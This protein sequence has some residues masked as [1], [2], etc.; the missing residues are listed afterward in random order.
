LCI[1]WQDACVPAVWA[2]VA[3]IGIHDWRIACAGR[4]GVAQ[5]LREGLAAAKEVCRTVSNCSQRETRPAATTKSLVAHSWTAV[6]IQGEV[7][8]DY[9]SILWHWQAS[10]RLTRKNLAHLITTHKNNRAQRTR[11]GLQQERVK[12][13]HRQ[14]FPRL[15]LWTRQCHPYYQSCW[16]R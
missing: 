14:L 3:I 10:V 7:S 9:N 13:H 12:L 4:P 2:A 1:W 16:T 5:L 11:R 6:N 15:R 8:R